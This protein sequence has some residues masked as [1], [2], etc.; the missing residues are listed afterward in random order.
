MS[1]RCPQC[2]S[3]QPPAGNAGG[4]ARCRHC[5]TRWLARSYEGM[6]PLEDHRL[7]VTDAVIIED[8]GPSTFN[9]AAQ[10][11]EAPSRSRWRGPIDRRIKM[12]GIA[13]AVALAVV[14]LG[15]PIVAALPDSGASVPASGYLQFQ[16]VRSETVQL[17]SVRTLIIQG[18]V[19]NRSPEAVALPAVEITLRSADGTPVTTWQID[20]AAEGLSGGGRIA[21]RSALNT[22][23]KEATQVSLKLAERDS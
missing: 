3:D 16:R 10:Q 6:L 20:L 21:F 4:M 17:G 12:A 2:G 5:G 22:P 23:P 7:M 14:T 15:A 1:I 13:V 18:E 9:A 8:T 11:P 19:V